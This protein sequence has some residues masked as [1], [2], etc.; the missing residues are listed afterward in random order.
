[1]VALAHAQD[2]YKFYLKSRAEGDLKYTLRI[3]AK[4]AR[5]R[6]LDQHQSKM[7]TNMLRK[8]QCCTY[9]RQ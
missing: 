3:L 2:R 4:H 7:K 8:G 9:T 5:G 6:G 1:M